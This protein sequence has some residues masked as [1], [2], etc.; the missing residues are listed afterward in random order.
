[1]LTEFDYSILTTHAVQALH[2]LQDRNTILTIIQQNTGGMV[3]ST[4]DWWE[5]KEIPARNGT[6]PDAKK[7]Y[8]CIS[9]A[10]K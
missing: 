8:G 5:Y 6:G 9:N 7:G 2:V 3:T 1:M 4:G 10:Q